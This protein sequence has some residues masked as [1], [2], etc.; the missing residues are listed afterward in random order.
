MKNLMSLH[1]EFEK[2]QEAF[3]IGRQNKELLEIAKVPYANYLLLSDR[4]EDALKAYKSA[5]RF[6]IS[7]KM[8]KDMAK[9]CIEE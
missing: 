4:Y 3:Q 6:D 5:G 8:T 7:M 9:N 1:V 2:W